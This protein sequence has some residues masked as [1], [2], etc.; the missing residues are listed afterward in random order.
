VCYLSLHPLQV[1]SPTCVACVRKRSVSRRTSSLTDVVMPRSGR[2]AARSVSTRFIA[3][4]T[5]DYTW[6]EIMRAPAD[7]VTSGW[8][9]LKPCPSCVLHNHSLYFLSTYYR[10]LRLFASPVSLSTSTPLDRYFFRSASIT[11]PIHFRCMLECSRCR[12]VDGKIAIHHLRVNFV[13][14]LHFR[15]MIAIRTHLYCD[16]GIRTLDD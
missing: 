3:S 9:P 8:L 14:D 2:S 15:Q 10:R 5:H 11:S 13:T 16:N 7:H 12:T 1:R 4:V 6:N